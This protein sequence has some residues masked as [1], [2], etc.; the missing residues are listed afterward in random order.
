MPAK[1]L[2]I[3]MLVGSGGRERTET[4]FSQFFLTAGFTLNRIIET[5]TPIRMLEAIA[6]V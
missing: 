1:I 6:H 4:E 3:E 2:D 5:G